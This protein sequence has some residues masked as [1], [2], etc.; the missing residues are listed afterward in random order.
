MCEEVLSQGHTHSLGICNREVDSQDREST[1]N[2][3]G[4]MQ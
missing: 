1:T 3:L 2:Q 4:N